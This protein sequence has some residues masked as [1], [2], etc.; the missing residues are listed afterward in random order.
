[1]L[2][3]DELIQIHLWHFEGQNEG[4]LLVYVRQKLSTGCQGSV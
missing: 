2:T 3:S 1:M 4:V